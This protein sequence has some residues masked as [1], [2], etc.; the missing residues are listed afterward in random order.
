MTWLTAETDPDLGLDDMP[1]W[2]R[3]RRAYEDQP[4]ARVQPEPVDD[5]ALAGH[6]PLRPQ[7]DERICPLCLEPL[8][9]PFCGHDWAAIAQAAQ[10]DAPDIRID[11]GG[12]A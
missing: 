1:W 4:L 12:T 11:L 7:P 9:G 8:D 6:D 2:L 3:G 5:P 10:E